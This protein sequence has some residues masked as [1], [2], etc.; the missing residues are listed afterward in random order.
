MSNAVIH[1]GYSLIRQPTIYEKLPSGY[2]IKDPP[3]GSTVLPKA[4]F[5]IIADDRN[6]NPIRHNKTNL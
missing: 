1:Q 3:V 6:F 4:G 2:F 5:N